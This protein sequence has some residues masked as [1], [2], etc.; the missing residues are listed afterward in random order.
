MFGRTGSSP[1]TACRLRCSEMLKS[2]D[3]TITADNERDGIW[4]G[5]S[6]AHPRHA[7]ASA[8]LSADH[9]MDTMEPMLADAAS[10][11]GI[12]LLMAAAVGFIAILL[13]QRSGSGCGCSCEK[14]I[15]PPRPNDDP[16][17]TQQTNPPSAQA[18][19]ANR[20]SE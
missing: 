11:I 12:I 16:A 1:R 5:R 4:R 3:L 19:D 6:H 15:C 9:D 13:R 18:D 7:F 2:T 20:R 14:L 8:R 17:D 10:I